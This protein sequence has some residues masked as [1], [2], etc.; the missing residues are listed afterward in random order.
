M[1]S[2]IGGNPPANSG[3]EWPAEDLGKLTFNYLNRAELALQRVWP[4]RIF[5]L[6]CGVLFVD[7]STKVLIGCFNF[8]LSHAVVD[9]EI[10]VFFVGISSALSFFFRHLILQTVAKRICALR[11]CCCLG[12]MLLRPPA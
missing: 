10:E 11:G 2:W 8:S 5:A 6:V 9:V 12:L 4:K 1:V 3:A 7:L